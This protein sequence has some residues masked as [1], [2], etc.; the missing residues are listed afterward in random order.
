MQRS[1]ASPGFRWALASLFA[2]T[3]LTG[4]GLAAADTAAEETNKAV[5]TA[6]FAYVYNDKS[7]ADAAELLGPR[8]IQHT[9]RI[10]DGRAGLEQYIERLRTE[11]PESS[12]EIKRVLTDRDHVIIQ[13]HL[14]REPGDRGAVAGDIFRLDGGRVVEHWGIVHPIT[15]A[16][17]ADNPNDVFGSS[18]APF[19]PTTSD[20]RER[21]N[22]ALA[23]GFYNAALNE[24]DWEKAESYI[25]DRYRQHSIYMEDGRAGFKGLIDRLIREFPENLGEIRQSFADGDMVVLHLHVTRTRETPGWTVIELMRLENE[26]VVEHWDIFEPVPATSANSNTLW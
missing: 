7:F 10:A 24:K 12:R 9:P 5:A 18:S 19:P 14:V 6:F 3:G 21:R 16:P 20:A 15:D 13:S 11:L 22:L 4:A 17:D 25:G 8:F 23:V 2:L 26:K 1:V